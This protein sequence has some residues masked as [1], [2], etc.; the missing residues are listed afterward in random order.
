MRGYPHVMAE[1]RAPL[2]QHEEPRDTAEDEL[3][4]VLRRVNQVRVEH[5]ADPIYE[6]PAAA[7][8]MTPGSTC[9]LQEAWADIGVSTVDYYE[10]R[11][12]GLR[13]EHGLSWFVRRF[14]EGAYPQLVAPR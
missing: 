14:D 5:G 12:P 3:G 10:A 4:E 6:L 2:T 11:G 7:P 13:V 9:V 1:V 8:A